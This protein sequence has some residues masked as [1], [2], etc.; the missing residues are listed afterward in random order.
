MEA[1]TLLSTTASILRA[2]RTSSLLLLTTELTSSA[3]LE[4]QANLPTSV[5]AISELLSNGFMM[6]LLRLVVTLRRSLSLDSLLGARKSTFGRTPTSKV[7]LSAALSPTL[8]TLSA[9]L[10][11]LPLPLRTIGMLLWLG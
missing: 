7:P 3:S 5:S 1:L 8:A 6:T 2:R 10:S 11:T 9:S 4:P